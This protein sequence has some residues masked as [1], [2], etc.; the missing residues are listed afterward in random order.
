MSVAIAVYGAHLIPFGA[1]DLTLSPFAVLRDV[2]KK[3]R[4]LTTG[5]G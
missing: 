3:T 1:Q 5:S 4:T 2:T